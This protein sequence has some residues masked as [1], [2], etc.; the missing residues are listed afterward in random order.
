VPTVHEWLTQREAA[1]LLGVHVSLVP[2]MILGVDAA[3]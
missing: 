1:E 2:K 3:R